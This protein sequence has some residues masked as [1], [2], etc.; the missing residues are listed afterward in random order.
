MQ[1]NE[2]K[3]DL[4]HTLKLKIQGPEQIYLK[5]SSRTDISEIRLR[6]NVTANRTFFHHKFK[7][8]RLF[9]IY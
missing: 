5:N 2:E 7:Y 1:R 9:E 4:L 8:N 3:S 6:N